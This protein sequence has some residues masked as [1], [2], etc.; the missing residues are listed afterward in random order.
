VDVWYFDEFFSGYQV[1]FKISRRM[2]L[3][4]LFSVLI[5]RDERQVTYIVV[6]KNCPVV[7]IWK[8]FLPNVVMCTF[9][10]FIGKNGT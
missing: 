5:G 2:F 4:Y 3:I 7:N 6:I 10:A 9:S 8:I 1:F